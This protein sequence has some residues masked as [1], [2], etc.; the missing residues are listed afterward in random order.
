MSF[1]RLSRPRRN[2]KGPAIRAWAR[3][4]ALSVDH[5][6]LPM[7]I[8]DVEGTYDI[9]SMPGQRRLDRDNL[10]RSVEAG[11]ELGLRSVVLFPAVDASKKTSD[12]REAH[13]PSGLVPTRLRELRT[14]FPEL[15]LITDVAL[16]PYSSDGH[17]G[18]VGPDGRILN[19]ETV[20]VLCSQ[21]VMQAEAGADVVAPSDMMDG[22][23]GA[24]R[25]AL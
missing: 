25:R 5:L 1:Q 16:D 23:I 4:T 10:F 12:G 21:A 3:E 17:D 22:R 11:L 6:I 24:I 19:D 13:N 7:F 2:R 8:H 20:E 9:P 14:R 15:V 18:L